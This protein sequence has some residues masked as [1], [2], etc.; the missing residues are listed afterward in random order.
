MSNA[1]GA[2]SAKIC[3]VRLRTSR[4][5]SCNGC[6]SLLNTWR[7]C[8][9]AVFTVRCRYDRLWHAVPAIQRSSTPQ[10]QRHLFCEVGKNDISSCPFDGEKSLVACPFVVE[11]AQLS[12]GVDLRVFTTYLIG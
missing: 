4:Y 9:S 3:R 5:R 12:R 7:R 1:S 10:A 2:S 11:P 8:V 6:I